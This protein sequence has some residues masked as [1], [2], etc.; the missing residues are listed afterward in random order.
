MNTSINWSYVGRAIDF[1]VGAGFQYIEV[2][3]IVSRESI[4][5]TLPVGKKGYTTELGGLVGS[6]EQSF[7]ELMRGKL[8]DSRPYVAATPCFRDDEPDDLH[9]PYFF[10]VELFSIRSKGFNNSRAF[11]DVAQRFFATLG[12]ETRA[13][14]TDAESYDIELNGV[15]IGS[16]GIHSIFDF[17]WTYGTGLA[18]PRFSYALSQKHE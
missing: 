6:A 11:L 14:W 2:P 5:S 8:I 15:E 13:V 4:L 1:Y 18:E 17:H 12:A 16:Y 7:I 9:N 10:K 3:W